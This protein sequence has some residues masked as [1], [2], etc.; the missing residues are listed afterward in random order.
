MR[1][2]WKRAATNTRGDRGAGYLSGPGTL[3]D[4]KFT[5]QKLS[6]MDD[7][8]NGISHTKRFA[9]SSRKSILAERIR[10][11][12]MQ[13]R[14][15]NAE[16]RARNAEDI[17]VLDKDGIEA[18]A[19]HLIRRLPDEAHCRVPRRWQ[20]WCLKGNVFIHHC[21]YSAH[22]SKVDERLIEVFTR[23]CCPVIDIVVSTEGWSLNTLS[24]F[25][26]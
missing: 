9:R 3:N 2:S 11:M 22:Q 16:T 8:L 4:V 7:A 12:K 10:V 25:I 13:G 5:L 14:V 15:V 24:I 26:S 19:R 17:Q 23:G 6:S 18:W 21:R 1:N 20:G